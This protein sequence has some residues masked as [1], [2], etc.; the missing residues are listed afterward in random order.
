M[1]LLLVFAC[2]LAV[3][4]AFKFPWEHPD[5]A[6]SEKEVPKHD[7]APA[8]ARGARYYN[9]SYGSN[10]YGYGGG[11]DSGY[12]GGY[13]S[14][15]GGGYGGGY[16]AGLYGSVP[17]NA[18]H[19]TST[20]ISGDQG[21]SIASGSS[22]SGR[23]KRATAPLFHGYET[24]FEGSHEV[25]EAE[26]AGRYGYGYPDYGYGSNLATQESNSYSGD[27]GVSMSTGSA[28]SGPEWRALTPLAHETKVEGGVHKFKQAERESRYYYPSTGYRR[29]SGSSNVAN[30]ESNAYSGYAGTSIAS[31]DAVAGGGRRPYGKSVDFTTHIDRPE[32]IVAFDSKKVDKFN[33]RN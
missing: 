30:Q 26:R 15:Y 9:P 3:S 11:Y 6:D 24:Q 12:G 19:Q 31:G 20:A 14:G 5:L 33:G 18:A 10:N 25:K 1:K 2:V 22:N 23:A 16:D 7:V 29:P 4:C 27:L 32:H 13:D 21:V 28:H 17:S 8:V